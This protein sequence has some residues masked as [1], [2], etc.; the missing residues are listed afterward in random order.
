M[1]RFFQWKMEKVAAVSCTL[2][3]KFYL[4]KG[5]NRIAFKQTTESFL[6]T[7]TTL[8]TK[9][10]ALTKETF[11]TNQRQPDGVKENRKK[12]WAS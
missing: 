10:L 8:T 12:I 11:G 1:H 9:F 2:G 7:K 3:G 5:Y 6:L 4:A